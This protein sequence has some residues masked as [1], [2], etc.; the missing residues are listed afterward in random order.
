MPHEILSKRYLGISQT[1]RRSD[2]EIANGYAPPRSDVHVVHNFQHDLESLWWAVLWTLTYRSGH[3]PARI[4]AGRIFQNQMTLP[5]ARIRAFEYSIV[6]HLTKCLS[7]DLQCFVSTM[8]LLREILWN[9]YILRTE[10]DLLF[11]MNSY[12]STYSFFQTSFE[13]LLSQHAH[14]RDYPLRAHEP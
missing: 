13:R 5:D 1:S 3:A 2:E 11:N 14:W 9:H 7:P 6:T 12:T 10:E 8:E 4:Y